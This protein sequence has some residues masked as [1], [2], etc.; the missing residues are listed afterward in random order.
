MTCKRV[1]LICSGKILK[2]YQ[3]L[4]YFFFGQQ[5]S[6]CLFQGNC[7][8]GI[9]GSFIGICKAFQI[10]KPLQGTFFLGR[11]TFYH[12]FHLILFI[13]VFV[14]QTDKKL[15]HGHLGN[16]VNIQFR[17]H[18]RDIV[19]EHLIAA[20]DI[21]ILRC[22]LPL[23]IVKNIGDSVHGNRCL[24]GPGSPLHDHVMLRFLTNRFIL[25]LLDGSNDLIQ[26][27]PLIFGQ[28]FC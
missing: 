15:F 4:F 2:S 10:P 8:N 28:I 26:Y 13:P 11:N 25:F 17:E 19:Q 3:Q 24:T 12:R 7:L 9:Q 27:R 1:D 22:K 6:T 20:D 5:N 21:E 16:T 23:I 14:Q 18:S